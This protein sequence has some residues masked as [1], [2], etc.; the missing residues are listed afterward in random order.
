[1]L[2]R[3]L[4]DK[5]LIMLL[6]ENSKTF[7]KVIDKK[8]K[9]PYKV[10]LFDCILCGSEIRAQS[11]Q[12]KNHSGKCVSCG[13]KNKPYESILNELIKTCKRRNYN[14]TINYDQFL[15]I[16]NLSKCHYCD[17][18][19]IFNQHT[20]INYKAVSRAYQLDR[21]NNNEGYTLENVVPCCW[22]CNRL[23]SDI[24][25]Y[26]EFIKLSPILKEIQKERKNV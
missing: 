6:K 18:I 12:L 23:K 25:T 19:L 4:R 1:M 22:E 13:H 2:K 20:R 8:A 9:R 15:E 3:G 11:G 16:I 26:E 7:E 21:K 10:Y 14:I 17:K 5:F 24:Y